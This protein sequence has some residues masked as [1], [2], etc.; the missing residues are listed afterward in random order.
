LPLATPDVCPEGALQLVER[1]RRPKPPR[2]KG[3]MFI[4]ILK[5]K[6]RLMPIVKAEVAKNLKQLLR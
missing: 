2:N 5:E 1:D 3:L 6:Q 4:R